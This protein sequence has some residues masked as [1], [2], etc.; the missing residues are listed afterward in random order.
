MSNHGRW[1]VHAQADD[2]SWTREALTCKVMG[3]DGYNYEPLWIN[4]QTAAERSIKSGD[5]VKSYNERGAVL[6]GAYV[7]ERIM[8]GVVYMDHGSRCDW[9]IPGELDRGGAID[10]ITPT[11]ITSK[12]A[13]GH[14]VSGYLVE[15]EKV[16]M[17]Q[18][19]EWKQQYPD[20]FE[21]E[22]DPASGLRFNGWVEG[23]MY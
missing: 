17:A 20:A 9:I 16:T 1:R 22:Y 15:V 13:G 10:L 19:E 6:G 12:H 21:R 11:G 2:I 14:T 23:G 4:T 3:P 8:P 7:S 5:I 18:M